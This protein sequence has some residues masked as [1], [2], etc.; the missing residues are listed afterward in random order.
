MIAF[1]LLR[2]AQIARD[3]LGRMLCSGALA[4]ARVFGF[5]ERRDDH[6][7]YPHRRYPAPVR[8]LRWLRHD[9]VLRYGRAR[10]QCRDAPVDSA[11]SAMGTDEDAVGADSGLAS[12]TRANGGD[13][14]A[15]AGDTDAS[16]GTG[17]RAIPTSRSARSTVPSSPTSQR[18]QQ[19]ERRTT[20]I[21]RRTSRTTQR[22]LTGRPRS[23]NPL[24]EQTARDEPG[25]V[26]AC[27]RADDRSGRS[28]RRR[29]R[30]DE[31][32]AT[33]TEFFALDEPATEPGQD[34]ETFVTPSAMSQMVFVD[35]VLLLPA[36]HP[37]VILQEADAP[38]RELRI[39]VGGAEGIAISYAAK[40][41]CDTPATHPRAV[42]A[43]ARGVRMTLDVVRITEVRGPPSPPRWSSPVGWVYV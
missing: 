25:P 12:T 39:P 15:V 8:E 42:H 37:V 24:D 41:A 10:G 16:E 26:D 30:L 4:L 23:A 14:A 40:R 6:R 35:V 33:T 3:P 21:V 36:T 31:T 17:H 2:A 11:M 27:R 9:R 43:R 34:R 18:L 28:R 7:S 22:R 38:F 1:R 13:S 32:T 29:D 5:P 20:L 19:R